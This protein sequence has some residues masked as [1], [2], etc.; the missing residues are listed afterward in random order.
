MLVSNIF[1]VLTPKI[2]EDEPVLTTIFQMGWNHQP[3]LLLDQ[4]F[5]AQGLCCWMPCGGVYALTGQAQGLDKKSWWLNR[6]NSRN[7]GSESFF[8]VTKRIRVV[9]K[10]WF[11][12]ILWLVLD[13]FVFKRSH[14]NV[15]FCLRGVLSEMQRKNV[16]QFVA[17]WDV[18]DKNMLQL[19]TNKHT[20]MSPEISKRL[21]SVGYNP[22]ISHSYIVYKPIY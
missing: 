4:H 10:C 17:Y 20:W 1:L 12:R 18:W 14:F 22:N 6:G 19:C 15:K 5:L 11:W 21:G 2:G 8:C 7:V 9:R 13:V 16:E 3:A